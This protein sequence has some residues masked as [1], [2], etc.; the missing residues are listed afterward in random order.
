[1]NKITIAAIAVVFI[2][3]SGSAISLASSGNIN[4]AITTKTMDGY[5]VSYNSTSGFI[6]DVSYEYMTGGHV[7]LASGIYVNGTQINTNMFLKNEISLDS[8]RVV[9]FGNNVPQSIGIMTGSTGHSNMDIHLNESARVLQSNFRL[10]SSSQFQFGGMG[11]KT[12]SGMQFRSYEIMNGNFSGVI[13][14]DGKVSLTGSNSNTV[15]SIEQVNS[16][17]MEKIT[18]LFA[19]FVTSQNIQNLLQNH[20][21][22]LLSNK[23]AYNATTGKVVGKYVSFQFNNSTN[24]VSNMNLTSHSINST[25]FSS[26]KISGNGTIGKGFNIPSFKI[27]SV[28]TYGSIF[29]YANDTYIMTVHDNP[30]AQSSYIVN[31]GTIIFS[32]PD[33]SNV[34][35]LRM[36]GFD[37]RVN[38][39]MVLSGSSFQEKEMFGLNNRVSFGTEV[40]K[41]NTPNV[42]EMMVVNGGNITVKNNSTITVKT[43]KYA[44]INVVVPPGLHNLGKYEKRLDNALSSGKIA[45]EL[46]IN[47]NTNSQNF[48]MSFNSTVITN[49]TSI[50]SGHAIISVSALPGHKQ[51]TNVVIFLSNTF[52]QNSH[53]VYIKFDGTVISSMS[54]NGLLNDTSSV[55][56]AY[57][58]YAESNGDLVIM[59]IPHFSKHTIEVSNT[60]FPSTTA[61]VSSL[62]IPVI[63]VVIAAA[64][65]VGAVVFIRKRNN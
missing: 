24:T 40:L 52:L 22:Q 53:N 32:L 44:M 33:H 45:A 18:P 6:K 59:H 31:N 58:V 39:S 26:V 10:S 42:T 57:S 21:N 50:S 30:V 25:L 23:F 55:S 29:F 5:S 7:T 49:I 34:S 62:L 1:M 61:T 16:T 11:M 65:I 12:Y 47:G 15:M 38:E 54:M 35:M 3:A 37:T 4:G 64:V 17:F 28:D 46:S 8:G 19:V 56:A 43:G 13:V 41:I 2:L 14:T 20:K 27:G 63:G 51:G 36:N 9:I 60:E 48:T